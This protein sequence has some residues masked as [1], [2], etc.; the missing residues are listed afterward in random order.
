MRWWCAL[1]F[2]L[3]LS[4][5]ALEPEPEP[6]A[7]QLLLVVDTDALV[8]LAPGEP[9][10]ESAPAP[11]FDRLMVEMYPPGEDVPCTG[12]A[13]EFSI[14][15]RAFAEGKVSVGLVP[16]PGVGGFRVRIALYRSGGSDLS[17]PRAASTIAHVI[18]L[19]TTPAQGILVGK[20]LLK[21]D[22]VGNPQGSLDAPLPFTRGRPGQS[23]VGSFARE[24]RRSCSAAATPEQVCIPGG[25]FWMGS[26]QLPVPT[27]QLVV[28][29]AFFLDAT[30]VTVARLRA[31]PLAREL[32]ANFDY[33]P[34]SAE[35]PFCN[36]SATPADLDDHPM[37]CV[38]HEAAR[39]F[40]ERAGGRLPTEAELAY[41]MSG[42][43]GAHFVWG[44]G[45][46]ACGE[47]AIARGYASLAATRRACAKLGIGTAKAASSARDVLELP[48]GKV[49]DLVGNVFEL[50]LDDFGELDGPC[51]QGGVLRDPRCELGES[52]AVFRGSAWS[53]ALA[54]DV[55]GS[56]GRIAKGGLSD[57]LGF[58]CAR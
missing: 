22:E 26:L 29:S 7:G 46:P 55:S 34:K 18:A 24:E 28:V 12:C 50:A 10:D 35:R 14:T 56:R 13:R 27:E 2:F 39:R 51:W 58:R 43:T 11:L 48:G 4:C 6:P 9:L 8:P 49:F 52:S 44:D 38:S 42:R 1:G 15:R 31:S 5:S 21:T 45:L 53:D 40:C 16:R 25:A 54:G 41:A 17:K 23:L 47:A 57:E 20:V 19:P 36:F 37:N 33:A 32:V 30:E 3:S